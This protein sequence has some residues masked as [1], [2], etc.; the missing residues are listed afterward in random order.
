MSVLPIDRHVAQTIGILVQ[1][2][3]NVPDR[4]A[5]EPAEHVHDCR[6]ERLQIGMLHAIDARD[7]AGN[8]LGVHP[9]VDVGRPEAQ[10]LLERQANGG[11][12]GHVVGRVPERLG[13]LGQDGAVG[14]V[15]QDRARARGPGVAPR[16]AV[17]VDQDAQVVTRPR[18]RPAR[19]SPTATR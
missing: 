17:G 3:R 8:Q 12:F 16:G 11:P 18:W 1:R 10:G 2:P 7:L 5:V 19:P 6:V 9:Q 13:D 14:R 15:A 4:V